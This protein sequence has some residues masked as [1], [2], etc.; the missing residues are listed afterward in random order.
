VNQTGD[1]SHGQRNGGLGWIPR[2]RN[3]TSLSLRNYCRNLELSKTV[4]RQI[5]PGC[6]LRNYISNIGKSAPADTA[7]EL[8]RRCTIDS[9]IIVGCRAAYAAF[10]FF[11]SSFF[12]T[13]IPLSMCFS[14]I[15][16]GGRNRRTVS[17]VLLNRTPSASAASTIGRAGISS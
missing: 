3:S 11:P 17:C 14:S 16:K 7:R 6:D 12:N 15:R 9:E 8:M 10:R 5:R 4:A 1:H 13:R 2:S